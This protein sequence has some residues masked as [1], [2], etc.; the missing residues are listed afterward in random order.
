M[1]NIRSTEARQPQTQVNNGT[2]PSFDQT[3][4]IG[5]LN[6]LIQKNHLAHLFTIEVCAKVNMLWFAAGGH[7]PPRLRSCQKH[8][9]LLQ[10]LD[11]L[12]YQGRGFIH[13][14]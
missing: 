7:L 9:V 4:V 12:D 2:N 14:R 13:R 1:F 8:T 3:F 6:Q 5:Q 10:T 11:A